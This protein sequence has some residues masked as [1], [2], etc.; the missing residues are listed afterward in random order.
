MPK[1][2]VL[3]V[4]VLSVVFVLIFTVKLFLDRNRVYDL[5]LATAGEWGEY[6]RFGNELARV[7]TRHKP[8]VRIHV[9]PTKGSV[10]NL[11]LLE[12]EKVQLAIAQNNVLTLHSLSTPSVRA[13]ASLFPEVFH[14]I[15][16][17]NSAIRTLSDLEGKRVARLPGGGGSYHLFVEIAGHYGLSENDFVFV[18]LSPEEVLDAFRAGEID[19]AFH[20][21]ALGNEKIREILTRGHTRLLALDQVAAM[22]LTRPYLHA[23]AIPRGT[24]NASPPIPE[25]ELP[26]AFVHAMLLTHKGVDRDLIHDLTQILYE[27][28]A[29]LVKEYP[30]AATI[31]ATGTDKYVSLPVHP[32]TRAYLNQDQPGFLVQYAEVLGLSLSVVV[33]A[34][35]GIWQLR[36]RLQ[37]RQKNRADQYNL[38]I[39]D[40]IDQVRTSRSPEQLSGIREQLIGILRKVIEDLDNDR[41]SPE[42]FQSFT[43]PWQVAINTIRHREM[44]LMNAASLEDSLE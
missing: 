25:T 39:L 5:T 24:Y 14:L 9:I 19:A 1:K 29:E 11:Q 8:N 34:V 12:A 43:F 22:R 16:Q 3:S 15:V 44:M 37:A 31:R 35:S 10:E 28:H 42:S 2:Y 4:V 26:A 7:L 41:I 36:L 40:L 18:D 6:Y 13:V 30:L 17:E 38:D 27:H 23:I 20:T 21:M 32:G 33:L